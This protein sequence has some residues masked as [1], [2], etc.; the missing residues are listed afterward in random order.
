M[1][2]LCNLP[3]VIVIGAA[4]ALILLGA[5][6][7]WLEGLRPE[8][9]PVQSAQPMDATG[10]AVPGAGLWGYLF[11]PVLSFLGHRRWGGYLMAGCLLLALPQYAKLPG[12][13][14]VC[15]ASSLNQPIQTR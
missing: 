10:T 2:T 5:V 8:K 1:I 6:S 9:A 15:P 4:C 11:G 7:A 13:E 3:T 12:S 14:G